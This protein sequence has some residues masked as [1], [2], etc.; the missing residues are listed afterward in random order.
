MENSV[1]Q[2]MMGKEKVNRGNGDKI[3][4]MQILLY[5]IM[6]DS[7][8]VTMYTLENYEISQSEHAKSK[9]RSLKPQ[10]L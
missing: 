6:N 4:R 10:P 2:D 7:Q 5:S 9:P 8:L 3:Q 1:C